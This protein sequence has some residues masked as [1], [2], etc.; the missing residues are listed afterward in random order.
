MQ[1][2]SCYDC[3]KR[4]IGC[5]ANCDEYKSQRTALEAMRE[6]IHRNRLGD[7]MMAEYRKR[8]KG[9]A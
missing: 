3:R 4:Y 5:H 8:K 6:V 7:I 1:I 9:Y 2:D